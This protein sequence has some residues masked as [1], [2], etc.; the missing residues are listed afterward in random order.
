MLALLF[1]AFAIFMRFAV[2]LHW[3]DAAFG[4]MPVAAALLFFGARYPR[5]RMWMPLVAFAAADVALNLFVYRFPLSIL[6]L[7]SWGW[8]AGALLLGGWLHNNERPLR[9]AG[10][11]FAASMSFFLISNGA[12]WLWDPMYVKTLDGLLHS[13]WMGLPFFRQAVAG[14]LFYTAAFFGIA[15]LVAGAKQVEARAHA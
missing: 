1:I 6:L 2:A 14:D 9:L 3:V 4:F 7:G 13:Y 11:A 15:A 8:Y 5:S 12:A 10:S